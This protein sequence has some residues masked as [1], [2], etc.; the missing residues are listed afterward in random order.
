MIGPGGAPGSRSSRPTPRF[1]TKHT[2]RLRLPAHPYAPQVLSGV[3]P[4]LLGHSFEVELR[5]HDKLF[6]EGEA[7]QLHVLEW[8]TSRVLGKQPGEVARTGAGYV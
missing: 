4:R 8:G 3:K 7:D 2:G 1:T 5:L 6:G